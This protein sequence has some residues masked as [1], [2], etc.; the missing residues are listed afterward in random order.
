[1]QKVLIKFDWL[2]PTQGG[3]KQLP[4]GDQ[5]IAVAKFPH[6]STEEWM[7][8]AWS[9]KVEWLDKDHPGSWYG[10]AYFLSTDS[11]TDWLS[12]EGNFELFE[13]PRCIGRANILSTAKTI[14]NL[15][16]IAA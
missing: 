14:E 2:H 5:Y 12:P 13:G 1:M 4:E 15:R 8:A 7:A 11:P 16:K 9:I 10:L 6:Q 3:R